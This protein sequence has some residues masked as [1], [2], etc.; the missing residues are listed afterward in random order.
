M[1]LERGLEKGL[2]RGLGRG[3]ERELERFGFRMKAWLAQSSSTVCFP[4]TLL[5]GKAITRTRSP[6]WTFAESCPAQILMFCRETVTIH[7]GEKKSVCIVS[8]L[9]KSVE[10]HSEVRV[11]LLKK[12]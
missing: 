3:L 12:I 8:T 6:D 7:Q 9:Y 1:G 4:H 10:K 11:G 2:E 5:R